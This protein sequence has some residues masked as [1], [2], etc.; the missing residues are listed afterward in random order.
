MKDDHEKNEVLLKAKLRICGCSRI[1]IINNIDL[2][3]EFDFFCEVLEVHKESEVKYCRCWL[4]FVTKFLIDPDCNKTKKKV[5]KPIF[6]KFIT[7][8][9]K[10]LLHFRLFIDFLN[11]TVSTPLRSL[12]SYTINYN[13][14]YSIWLSHCFLLVVIIFHH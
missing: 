3:R 7:K 10:Q 14:Q 9:D 13:H 8:C 1:W 6:K 11:F 4:N 2:S 5:L 12:L